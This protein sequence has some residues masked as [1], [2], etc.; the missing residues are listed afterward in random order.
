MPTKTVGD[1][2]GAYE[3]PAVTDYGSIA[4]HTFSRCNPEAPNPTPV[5]DFIEVPHHI[6]N[7]QECSAL[8]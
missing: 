6:D 3:A 2:G 8:S 5:K 7:H 1:W 4:D